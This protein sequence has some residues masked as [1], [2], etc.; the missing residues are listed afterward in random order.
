MKRH[1]EATHLDIKRHFCSYCPKA[2]SQKTA[3]QVHETTHTG[4]TPLQC[5]YLCGK[6][7]SD[8]GRRHKHQVKAH[9]Y[10]PRQSE[11]SRVVGVPHEIRGVKL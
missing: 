7:F 11:K 2:F 10:L 5:R 1:I 4:A 3:L 8:P 6:M 9:G